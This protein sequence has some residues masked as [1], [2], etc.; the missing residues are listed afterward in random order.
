MAKKENTTSIGFEEKIWRAADVLRGNLDA[1]EYKSVVLG[2]IF[3]KYISD[4]F[5]AK[6]KELKE[7][8]WRIMA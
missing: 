3:L 1:A 2:L 5:E 6:Y 4:K 7:D 8:E